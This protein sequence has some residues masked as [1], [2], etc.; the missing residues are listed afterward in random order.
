MKKYIISAFILSSIISVTG[1]D[2]FLDKQKLAEVA[3]DGFYKKEEN[4]ILATNGVYD[5]MGWGNHE[6]IFMQM[7]GDCNSDDCEVGGDPSAY[8]MGEFVQYSIYKPNPSSFTRDFIQNYYVGIQRA[9]TFLEATTDVD[10]DARRL[11]GEV[12]FMRALYYFDL[13]R[14]FGPVPLITKTGSAYYLSGNR[15]AGDDAKGTKQIEKIYSVIIEDLKYAALVLP[16]KYGAADAGRATKGAA[17]GLLAKVYAFEASYSKNNFLF[18]NENKTKLWENV[19]AYSDSVEKSGVYSLETDYHKLFDLSGENGSESLFEIQY[20]SGSQGVGGGNKNEGT[21]KVVDFSPR[22]WFDASSSTGTANQSKWGYGLNEPTISLV[23]Q[24]DLNDGTAN[25]KHYTAPYE[26][27]IPNATIASG[28]KAMNMWIL[29]DMTKNQWNL[30]KDFV[31]YDPRIDMIIKPNDSV[32]DILTDATKPKYQRICAFTYPN[33][34]LSDFACSGYWNR[35]TLAGADDPNSPQV[36]GLNSPILRFADILLL[37]AEAALELGNDADALNAV[38]KVRARARASRWVIDPTNVGDNYYKGYKIVA[39]TTP[40]NLTAVTL[41]DIYKERRLE[42]FCEGHRF[43]DLV[44]WGKA[45]EICGAA[46]RKEFHKNSF[47]WKGKYSYFQPIPPTL[48]S[49]G[50]GNVVQNPGY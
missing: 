8:D 6:S 22:S 10:Y 18:L 3:T 1:C 21:I 50:K 41:D 2:K 4:A 15:Q 37:K 45:D 23:S 32:L 44:R 20:V 43:F 30:H 28:K 47:A 11:R 14:A 9:N 12:S 35:K 42:L 5:P 48:I 27:Q 33:S 49:E 7:I 29:D 31:D 39:G 40:T 19:L 26:P 34:K 25:I 36:R 17:W 24:F 13:V 38:N 16:A 46:G